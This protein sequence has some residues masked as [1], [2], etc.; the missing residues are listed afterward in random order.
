M[1]GYPY[2]SV[3]DITETYT[4]EAHQNPGVWNVSHFEAASIMAWLIETYG[5]DTVLKNLSTVPE[6]FETVYG[7]PFSEAYQTWAVWNL[8]KC[9]EL[10]LNFDDVG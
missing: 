7:L 8:E 9:A 2:F 4:E 3:K 10:G 5:R 6:E 1:I